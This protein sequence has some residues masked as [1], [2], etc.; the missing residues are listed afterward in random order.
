MG[1][2]VLNLRVA[3]LNISGGE[4]TFEEFPH[5]TRQSRLE[6]LKILIGR[7]DADVLCLQEVS[8]YVDA[9]GVS[10]SLM[11]AVNQAGGYHY[12]GYGKTLSMET[13]MQVKKDVMVAG[14]FNDWWDWSKGNSV[15]ARIPFARLGDPQRPGVPRNVPLYQP[16]QYE[17]TRDSDPRYALLTRLKQAPYPYVITVHLSTLVGERQPE[18][19][20]DRVEQSQILRFQQVKR[21]LDLVRVQILAQGEPLILA[22]DFN[23]DADEFCLAHL[24]EA[25]SGFVRLVPENEQP[26]HAGS[27]K[28]IDHIFFFPQERLVN[29]HCRIEEGDLSRRASD[30]LPI[31]ADLEIR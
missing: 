29:Y 20:P 5:D 21:I 31:M 30:H 19:R 14:I 15:H 17:G 25:E 24:L 27:E 13:H 16:G 6:A 3:T 11:D 22:G 23:A 26:S 8:Q 4:K 28:L 7:L 18:S 10:H 2:T 9:D 12:S 1:M